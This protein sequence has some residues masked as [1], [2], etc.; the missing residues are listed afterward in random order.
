[1][2]AIPSQE[3]CKFGGES[4]LNQIRESDNLEKLIE[5]QRKSGGSSN[6]NLT[7]SNLNNQL[8]SNNS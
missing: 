1:M 5:K 4:H 6:V 3:T 7:T 8:N 2:N